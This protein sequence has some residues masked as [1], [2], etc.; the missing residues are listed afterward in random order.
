VLAVNSCLLPVGALEGYHIIT[1]EGLG[2][3]RTG[4]NQV[5]GALVLAVAV[6]AAVVV[7]MVVVVV[8]V[9]VVLGGGAQLTRMSSCGQASAASVG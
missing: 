7:V 5:Q 9:E 1:S 2:N 6:V 8:V 4:F 3:S